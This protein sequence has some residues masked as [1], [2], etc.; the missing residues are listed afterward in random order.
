[1]TA[2]SLLLLPG[3]LCDATLF[4]AQLDY[5]SSHQYEVSV[6]D[7]GVDNSIKT[8]AEQALTILPGPL[9]VAGLSMGGIIAFE[10]VRQAPQRIERLALLDTNYRA[11]TAE[12]VAR[13]NREI[14]TVR[15]GG[16]Q[17][18]LSLIENTYYPRYV[19]PTRLSDK[20]LK[21]VVLDMAY[22]TGVQAFFNQWQALEQRS[23]YA[24]LLPQI[25]CPTLV[26]CGE[27]DVMC[28]P[29]LHRTMANEIPGA[30]L[31]VIP[32]CGH[33]STLEAPGAVNKVLARW[34]A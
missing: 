7:I 31:E 29:A 6:A 1:M 3:S 23:D 20:A 34:L 14:E 5:F 18:L 8:I 19:A 11:E 28:N 22:N 10:M 25:A 21:T 27:E 4:Q 9:A 13:R 12:G 2:T 17:A 32:N 30:V 15:Q 26:L 24:E 16:E 33:L